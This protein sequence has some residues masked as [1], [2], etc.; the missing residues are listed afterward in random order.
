MSNRNLFA[1]IFL[2]S[3]GICL[4]AWKLGMPILTS[5]PLIYL[6]A[7]LLISFGLFILFQKNISKI[8]FL[9]IF[10]LILSFWILKILDFSFCHKSNRCIEKVKIEFYQ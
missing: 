7:G 10:S 2:I 1:G 5:I 9:S 4:I 8:I 3:F 6:S